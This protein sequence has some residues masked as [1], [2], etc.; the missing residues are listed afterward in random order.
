MKQVPI[1]RSVA[2][3]LGLALL[4]LLVAAALPL[5]ADDTVEVTAVTGFDTF[6]VDSV[7]YRLIGLA[8][9]SNGGHGAEE[10][11]AYLRSLIEGKSIGLIA[12]SLLP[13]APGAP[14]ARFATLG[15]MPINRLMI[16]DGYA[17]P[18]PINHSRW[19]E[20]AAVYEATHGKTIER[21]PEGTTTTAP[22]ITIET[23]NSSQVLTPTP[24][25]PAKESTSVQCSATTKKGSRCSRK[26]TNASGK[27]WQHE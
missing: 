23:A 16:A 18:A 15:R 17:D 9:P 26:T 11:A 24:S 20:F 12:D 19:K 22:T 27:C 14:R 5:R 10:C 21:S 7:E 8:L 3:R 6:R 1:G 2:G 13:D 4:I 25:A